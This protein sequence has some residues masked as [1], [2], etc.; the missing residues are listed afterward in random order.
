MTVDFSKDSR[1]VV[2]GTRDGAVKVFEI[3]LKREISYYRSVH[4]GMIL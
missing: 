4:S 2:V 1:Y 3:K